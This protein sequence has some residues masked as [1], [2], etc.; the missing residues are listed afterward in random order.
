M[1]PRASSAD[2]PSRIIGQGIP[3]VASLPGHV[4]WRAIISQAQIL[5]TAASEE[6]ASYSEDRS[7]AWQESGAARE[8]PAKVELLQDTVSQMQAIE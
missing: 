2:T 6:M 4:C 1:L 3:G 8:M 7:D 5:L